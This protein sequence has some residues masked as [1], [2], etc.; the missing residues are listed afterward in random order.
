MTSAQAP[1]ELPIS[2]A[3][4]HLADVVGRA[5]YAGQTTYVTRR[6]RRVAAVVPAE[7]A[8]LL[9]ELE[10][11]GLARL[12]AEAKRELDAGAPTVKLEALAAE[13]GL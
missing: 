12:A 3:R 8:E 5:T 7:A 1:D 11:L 2:D 4:E 6:G 10:D 13:L 9:D